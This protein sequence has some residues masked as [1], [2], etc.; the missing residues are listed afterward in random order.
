VADHR[1]PQLA[2]PL[3]DIDQ[4]VNDAVFH[5]QDQVQIAQ[6]DVSVDA[7]DLLAECRQRN[8]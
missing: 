3:H 8:T 1:L 5:P 6:A 2:A 4:I 7:H